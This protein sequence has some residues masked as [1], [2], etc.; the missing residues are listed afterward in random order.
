MMIAHCSIPAYDPKRVATVLAEIL[1]GETIRFPPAG[2]DGWMA[3]SRDGD[4]EIEV[5]PRGALITL[6]ADQGNWRPGGVSQKFSEVHVAVCVDRPEAEIIAIAE[7]AGWP[8]RHCERGGG[9]FS[10]VE[11]WV[12]GAF[13]IEFLDPGQ[14]QIYKER[15]TLG[16]W[17]K[18]L[19][20]MGVA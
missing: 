17:K 20:E 13:M 11:V 1:E 3:W 7:R 9:Y 6:E 5:V 10:L 4:I 19:A 2:P 14:T 15:I 12:E 18:K 16:N 8:A